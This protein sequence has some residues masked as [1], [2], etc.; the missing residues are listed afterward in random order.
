MVTALFNNTDTARVY[1]LWQW[2]YGQVLQIQG[3]SLDPAVEIHFSIQETGGETTTR[4]GVTR[5]G[6]TDVPIPDSMLENGGTTQDY[7]IYA[8]IY[9]ADESSGETIKKI[10]MKVKS[11]PKPQAFSKPEDAQLFREAIAAVNK[12]ATDAQNAD[13]SA[14]AWTHGDHENYPERDED[15]AAYYAGVAKDAVKGIHGQVED[16]KKQIDTYVSG[17]ETEL[18]GD[19]GNVIF[20]CFKVTPPKLFLKNDANETKI[21]FR[22]NN[23]RLE[24]KWKEVL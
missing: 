21:D 22:V 10:T 11:R 4:I 15:N 16:A 5:D 12:S 19:T 6:V 23:G 3:L 7:D 9:L 13:K 14:E 1:G 8:W 18:K 24:Y 2:D 17:K 20:P